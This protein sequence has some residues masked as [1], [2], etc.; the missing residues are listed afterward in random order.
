MSRT[1]P[2]RRKAGGA[3]LAR[4]G[5][6]V[7]SAEGAGASSGGVAVFE[8]SRRLFA[9]GPFDHM[10][11]PDATSLSSIALAT[12]EEREVGIDLA[13][14]SRRDSV[15]VFGDVRLDAE[16][17]LARELGGSGDRG[18]A[19]VAR[20]Y[21]RWQSS[22]AEHLVGDFAIAVIDRAAN[23]VVASRDAFGVRRLAYRLMPNG[24]ALGADV[25]ALAA[26]GAPHA[27]L[28]DA[29]VSMYLAGQDLPSDRTLFRTVFRVPPGHTLIAR[30]RGI[31]LRRHFAPSLAERRGSREETVAI[32]RGSFRTAVAD[33]LRGDWPVLVQVSGGIDSGSIACTADDLAAPAPLH[34]VSARF[35][36]VDEQRF[37][38]AIDARL[39][40]RIH[41]FDADPSAEIDDALEPGHPRRY[42]LAAQTVGIDALAA[43]TRARAVLSGIGGDELFFERGVYRDLAADRRWSTLWRETS[44]PTWY[45]TASR[46]YFLRDAL[47]SLVPRRI[48]SV[49]AMTRRHRRVRRPAWLRASPHIRSAVPETDAGMRFSSQTQRFTWAWLTS[50]RLVATLEAEDRSAASAGLQ[51]RYPFLDSRLAAVIL[52]TPYAHRLPSGRMKLLLR[53][54]LGDTLPPIIRER[55]Q[56]TVFDAA[57]S[58]AVAKKLPALREAVE[59]GPWQSDPWVDRAGARALLRRV[60][61]HP[62]DAG[63][64]I[65][66]WDVATLELWLRA[67]R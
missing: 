25:G 53:D 51:M 64:A 41:V 55:M 56:V 21:E 59:N 39:R 32:V 14:P 45:T 63:L 42:P 22:F 30:P 26:L 24:I 43:R 2:R 49:I 33:R 67:L 50:P 35:H 36:G 8:G 65:A 66:L 6:S 10:E 52:A 7:G 9:M 18:V 4:A 44:Q 29:A 54:A 47:R 46:S 11:S 1:F 17:D 62:Q 28:D 5:V 23:M 3:Y 57:I 60:E 31:S 19:L 37:V 48:E 61:A 27:E 15:R 12:W 40:N 16:G 34:F 58:T 38:A 20:A 13:M